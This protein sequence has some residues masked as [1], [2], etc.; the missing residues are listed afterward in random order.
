MR[1][2]IIELRTTPQF[3]HA[4]QD[5]FDRV[6]SMEG[7][8]LFR[9]DFKSGS[10]LMLT[11]IRMKK[12]YRLEDAKIPS[13]AAILATLEAKDDVYT[14]FMKLRPYAE[15]DRIVKKTRY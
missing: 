12:G 15:L 7:L 8:E 10:A 11:E 4:Q 14:C 9:V 5:I 13:E 6:E 2:V 1:K 3:K